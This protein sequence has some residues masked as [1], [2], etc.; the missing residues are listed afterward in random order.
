[1]TQRPLT[2]S[3]APLLIAVAGWEVAFRALGATLGALRRLGWI[4]PLNEKDHRWAELIKDG[5]SY[6]VAA[7]H[8]GI[9]A[10]R[11]VWHLATLVSAPVSA[12]FAMPLD[13]QDTWYGPS[14]SVEMTNLIF[15]SWLIFDIIHI[16]CSRG[17]LGGVDMIAH[18]TG[19]IACGLVCGS[20][21]VCPFPF[22]WLICGELSTPFLNLRWY[23]KLVGGNKESTGMKV[24]NVVFALLFFVSRV[25]VYGLG[26]AHIVANRTFL[27]GGNM[28]NIPLPLISLVFGL[29]TGGYAMNLVWWNK[30]FRLGMGWKRE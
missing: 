13:V 20:Y 3:P 30:V 21:R 27:M 6:G 29:L 26:L 28:N 10:T 1:M 25:V 22:A 14:N 11:G 19:F 5:P 2:S 17:R 12:Q 16:I 8:A 7:L 24:N 23:L 15:I 18:H 4:V 9:V